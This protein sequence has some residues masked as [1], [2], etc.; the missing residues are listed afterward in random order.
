ML[1]CRGFALQYF[2]FDQFFPYFGLFF[3]DNLCKLRV[4]I[5]VIYCIVLVGGRLF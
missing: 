3:L 2:S 1:E 5:L 4:T